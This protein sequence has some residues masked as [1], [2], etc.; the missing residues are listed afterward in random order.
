MTDGNQHSSMKTL[1]TAGLVLLLLIISAGCIAQPSDPSGFTDK[2]GNILTGDETEGSIL[3]TDGSKTEWYTDREGNVRY[4]VI[5]PD[6]TIIKYYTTPDG[7][8]VLEI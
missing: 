3:F 4:T 1:L 7:E 6:G 5:Q 2:D 8:T